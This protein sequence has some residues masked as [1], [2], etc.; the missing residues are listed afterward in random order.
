MTEEPSGVASADALRAEF[1]RIFAA[2]PAL[3]KAAE[4]ALLALRVGGETVAVRVLEAAGL[5]TAPPICA[6]PTRRPELLGVAGLRG[7]IVPVYSVARLLGRPDPGDAPRWLVLA[8]AG[9][10]ERVA[11]AFS[12]LD[13]HLRVP[14]AALAA[15]AP[16]GGPEHVLEVAS[17]GADVRPVLSVPSLVRVIIRR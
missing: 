1:D 8:A 6:V 16:G 4:V 3:E 5:V 14:A 13:G 17:L 10:D 12:A 7:A 2:A 15:S 11:L 9:G